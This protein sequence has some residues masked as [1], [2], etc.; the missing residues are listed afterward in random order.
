MKKALFFSPH[1]GIWLFGYQDSLISNAL[2]KS[3]YDTHYYSCNGLFKNLCSTMLAFNYKL[4]AA[5]E[6]KQQ[7]CDLCKSHQR[8][9]D[10]GFG[11]NTKKLDSYFLEDDQKKFDQIMASFEISK[12]TEIEIDGAP[13]GKWSLYEPCLTFKKSK[14]EFSTSEIAFVKNSLENTIKSYLVSKRLI[15]KINPKVVFVYNSYYGVNQPIVWLAKEKGIK[16]ISLHASYNLARH[17]KTLSFMN[18]DGA[19][20]NYEAINSWP[21][22]SKWPASEKGMNQVMQHFE[23]LL[24]SKSANAYSDKV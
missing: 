22:V 18:K 8:L 16:A 15:E 2:Q 9:F 10:A 7:V 6:Q 23:V 14:L 11:V 19:N 5:I 13:V 1:A 20:W 12:I 4:D 24:H 3:G 17:S 21:V